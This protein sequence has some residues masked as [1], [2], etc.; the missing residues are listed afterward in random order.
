MTGV[1]LDHEGLG[2]LSERLSSHRNPSSGHKKKESD[3]YLSNK[4]RPQCHDSTC[5][6]D[7]VE[8]IHVAVKVNVRKVEMLVHSNVFRNPSVVDALQTAH[9]RDS[10][11]HLS[12]AIRLKS[13]WEMMSANE[14]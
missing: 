12:T 9:L 11:A 7:N 6:G 2:V 1:E 3:T 8:S 13:C 10:S 5:K 4:P 14:G